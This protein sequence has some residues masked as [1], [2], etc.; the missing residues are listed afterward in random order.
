MKIEEIEEIVSGIINGLKLPDNTEIIIRKF[1]DDDLELQA[2]VCE[3]EGWSF[4]VRFGRQIFVSQT[5]YFSQSP[6]SHEYRENGRLAWGDTQF[7]RL[8]DYIAKPPEDGV[9]VVVDFEYYDT[10]N[11]SRNHDHAIVTILY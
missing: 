3:N 7:S 2:F 10:W 4:F 11:Q 6:A 1:E 9:I 5:E 8:G